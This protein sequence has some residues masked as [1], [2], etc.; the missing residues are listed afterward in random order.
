MQIS[1]RGQVP[2]FKVME[3]MTRV[4]Q[5]RAE[6]RPVISLSAGEPAAGAP[7]D[8]RQ[9]AIDVQTSGVHLGY[10]AIAG[11]IEL[12]EELVKHYRRWYNLEISADDIFLTTGASGAFVLAFLA[13]FNAGDRVALACPGYPAYRN[14]L[15]SVD[16][17]PVNLPAGPQSRFQP[18]VES[19]EAEVAANGPIKGLIIASPANPTGTMITPE[20]FTRISQWCR[21]NKVLLI[22]D[23]I[24][25]GITYPSAPKTLSAWELDR[26]HLVISSFSKYWGMPGS[27]LGW[28][29]VPQYLQQAVSAL[30]GNIAL[31]APRASQLAAVAGFTEASYIEAQ[32]QVAE[33]AANRQ[34]FLAALEQLGF[35]EPAPADGAFYVYLPLG[36]LRGYFTDSVEYC[37]Q[38]LEEKYVAI[39]PGLDFDP[40]YG[41]DSVRISFAVSQQDMAEAIKRMIEFNAA[42]MAG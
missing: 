42:V 25:H 11:R 6:D 15:Q 26:N 13:A 24:Y 38:L 30:A 29:L 31:C 17:V 37:A 20:E 12:R 14:I 1:Q 7:A 35:G 23:E 5:L 40:E 19:L 16:C 33:Y 8:V 2:S 28:M 32:S 36:R 18:T 22:S 34:M 41:A 3:I 21:A 4:A 27:R 9:A 10:T 39:V